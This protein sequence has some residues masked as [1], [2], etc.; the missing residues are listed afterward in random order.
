M[1]FIIYFI[2][3]FA[4]GS[5]HGEVNIQNIFQKDKGFKRSIDNHHK[6]EIISIF[7]EKDGYHLIVIS[8]ELISIWNY[9]EM[10]IKNQIKLT[11]HQIKFSDRLKI[12]LYLQEE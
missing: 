8:K 11:N 4:F 5:C 10:E 9:N 12:A 1:N 7:F 6:T 3:S 2:L